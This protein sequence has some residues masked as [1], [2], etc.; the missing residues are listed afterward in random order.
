[1]LCLDFDD[2][3]V[4]D[5]TMRQLMERF[6]DPAWRDLEADYHAGTRSVEQ[7]NAA[8]IELVTGERGEI[9]EYI[10]SVARPR[11]GGM[12]LLDW[13]KW[14]G[15]Q[16]IIVSNGYDLYI[17]P[18][19]RKLGAEGTARHAGRA[20]YRYRWQ[21]RYLS[22]RGIEVQE[23]F[24]VAYAAAFQQAG[25]FVAYVGDGRSDI[26]AARMAQAVF[27]RDTLWEQLSGE[28]PRIYPFETLHDVIAV[29]EREAEAWLASFS[30]T[31]AAGGSS[32]S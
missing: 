27:A 3:F 25:D 10:A 11:P 19:L 28:H 14:H 5:N 12:E 13:A 32:S 22:P 18:V 29:L 1:M 7:Y 4:L 6:A 17:D 9:E 8:A 21:V 26:E 16:A 15:W 23:R 31:T 2:T 20:A 30:S 24:K